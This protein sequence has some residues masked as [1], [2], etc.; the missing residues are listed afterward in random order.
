MLDC[1]QEIV[2]KHGVTGLWT[3]NVV[4]LLKIVPFHLLIYG[5]YTLIKP[6]L[7]DLKRELHERQILY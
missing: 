3:G 5:L 2:N 6:T 4:N 7:S 1:F